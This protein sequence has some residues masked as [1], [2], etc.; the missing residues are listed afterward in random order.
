ML[1]GTTVG[2]DQ[3]SKE[4]YFRNITLSVLNTT[5]SFTSINYLSTNEYQGHTLLEILN[6]CHYSKMCL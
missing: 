6:P 2:R 5:G 1:H 3:L 4:V